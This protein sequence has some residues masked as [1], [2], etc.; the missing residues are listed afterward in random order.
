MT[1]GTVPFGGVEVT[2]WGSHDKLVA[3]QSHPPELLA[4]VVQRF[5]ESPIR[6]DEY[7]RASLAHLRECTPS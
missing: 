7:G 4:E 6:T 5:G 3:P 1:P 2:G